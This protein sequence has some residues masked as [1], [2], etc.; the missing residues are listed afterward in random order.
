[1]SSTGWLDVHT[2]FN[3][4]MSDEEAHKLVDLFRSVNF[5]VTS[6][7][8]V[9]WNAEAIIKHNDNAGVTMSLLSYLPQGTD[10]LCAANDFAHSI[11]KK[12]PDRF[13]HLAALPTDD[14]DGCLKE[15]ERVQTFNDPP[16]DGYCTSTVRGET[17]LSDPSLE[18]VWS[19]LNS[20]NAVVHVHPNAYVKGEYG[21]PSP[22][23]DVAFDT[24][25]VATDMLYKGVFRRHPNIKFIFAHCGGALPVL[26]GRLALLGTEPWVPNPENLTRQEVEE[27]LSR[28][29]IDTAATAKTG[30]A[31]AIKMV[32]ASHCLYGA[33]CGVPCSTAKT[34]RENM[35]DVKRVEGECGLGEGTIKMNTWRL[36]PGAAERAGVK[37]QNGHV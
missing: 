19:L 28:L 23:I 26:S 10:K 14:P 16:I 21:K 15:I 22:L 11:V 2:H 7:D 17:P 8:Q 3:L 36:F 12:Y 18:P 32:G 34:M 27:Q 24:A 37:V 29:Y 4:P 35:E 25:R 13:G 9:T 1:M 33:D 20:Q 6:P 31:P 5:L 30:L